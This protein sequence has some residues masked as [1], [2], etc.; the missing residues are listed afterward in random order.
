MT[1]PNWPKQFRAAA[2]TFDWPT[3]AQLA[4]EYASHLY[5]IPKPPDSVGQ[6]LLVLRQ[7]R[8]YQEL[9]LVADAAL[10]H[11][12]DVPAVR[13]HYAQALV[14]GGH[15]A[16]ALRLFTELAGDETAS[17][18]DRIEARGGIGRCYKEMFLA[19]TE[20][21]R[22]RRFLSRSLEAYLAAYLEDPDIYT[23]H[24][25]NAV[26]LLARAARDG[27]QLPSGS[28]RAAALA[29]DIL[30]TAD[31]DP[32]PDMFTEVTACEAAIALGRYDEAVERAE[33]FIE[34]TPEMFPVATFLRQLQKVWQFDTTT[35]PGDDLLPVLRSA[36]LGVNGGQVTVASTDLRAARLADEFGGGRLEAILGRDRYLSLSWYRTGL[37][38]CRAVA[39]IQTADEQ[40]VGTGFLVAGPDLHPDLPPL[41]VVTNGHVVPEDLDPGHAHVAFHGLDEDPGRQARFRVAQQWWYQPS[42]DRGLD[43]TILELDGYPQDVVPTPLAKG[44]PPRPLS[45]RR[46]YVIGHPGGSAQPQFSLQDNILLDYDHRVL[47]YRSPT[48]GGS[49]GSPVSDDEW[50][51]IGLHHAGG[52]GMPQLNNAGGTYAA[53]EGIT[54]DAIRGGLA[55]Q[56][57]ECSPL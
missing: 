32:V 1:S 36:L 47:H 28:P 31:S 57:P 16:V 18:V 4:A 50:R 2:S 14:D 22:G 49:S 46:A 19:C 5:A 26:S 3:L 10:A 56:P 48:A 7:S 43:T 13:R 39:R 54:I 37:K 55:H 52:T 20:S 44:L 38:R 33:A 9:E 6:V 23:W 29:D 24:G 15:P 21:D 42:A 30:R 27:I 11:G 51:L 8:R 12:P 17:R 45:H 25:I 53:N 40:A 41:V 35:S 34:T